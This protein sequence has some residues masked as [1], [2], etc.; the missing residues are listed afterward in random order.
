MAIAAIVATLY[1][2]T[3]CL[4]GGERYADKSDKVPVGKHYT[5]CMAYIKN[6]HTIYFAVFQATQ[7]ATDREYGYSYIIGWI[8]MVLAALTATFYSVAG[9]Y[10]GGERY[11]EKVLKGRLPSLF[12]APVD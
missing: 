7:R 11:A 9:C 10:I 12:T 5:L 4:I 1:S 8:A 3:G 2:V 6:V